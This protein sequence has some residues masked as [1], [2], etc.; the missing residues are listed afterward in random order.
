MRLTETKNVIFW[1]H[2]ATSFDFGNGV[3]YCNIS[4]RFPVTVL[5]S[6]SSYARHTSPSLIVALH[7]VR[8]VVLTVLPTYSA[9]YPLFPTVHHSIWFVKRRMY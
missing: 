4:S 9:I 5:Y 6:D 7:S 1:C 3:S 2:T 8:S